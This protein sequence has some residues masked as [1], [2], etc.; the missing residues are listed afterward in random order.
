VGRSAEDAAALA[1]D[2]LAPLS[3]RYHELL[4]TYVIM[5]SGTLSAEITRFCGVLAAARVSPQA[6][7]HVHLQQVEAIVA[8]LGSRSSRHVMSRAD[9]L[10]LEIMTALAAAYQSVASSVPTAE[11]RG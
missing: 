7:L 4:R 6:V 5:G 3:R 9:L 1:A 8:G 10:A 11:S 2:Q